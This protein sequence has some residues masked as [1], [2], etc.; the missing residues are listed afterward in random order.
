MFDAFCFVFNSYQSLLKPFAKIVF[1]HAFGKIVWEGTCPFSKLKPVK[2]G[3]TQRTANGPGW[4]LNLGKYE[5][6]I[7]LFQSSANL[8][9]LYIVCYC[10]YLF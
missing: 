7:S 3:G 5:K 10:Y 2:F 4:G 6:I 8:E 9:I 1:S